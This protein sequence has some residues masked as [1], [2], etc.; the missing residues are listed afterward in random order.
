M[1]FYVEKP[2][3]QLEAMPQRLGQQAS[4]GSSQFFPATSGKEASS[5]L[6]VGRA[7]HS[8]L[9][10]HLRSFEVLHHIIPQQLELCSC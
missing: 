2:Q 10:S 4:P 9:S 7:P 6:S 1:M 5:F 8:T 3:Q